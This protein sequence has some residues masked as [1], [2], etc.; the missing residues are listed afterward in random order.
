VDA[1][2]AEYATFL[3]MKIDTWNK[4]ILLMSISAFVAL[5]DQYYSIVEWDTVRRFLNQNRNG[6]NGKGIPTSK[7]FAQLLEITNSIGHN[8]V[9]IIKF[10]LTTTFEFQYIFPSMLVQFFL[11]SGY[12]LSKISKRKFKFK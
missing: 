2:E 3:G 11:D 4:V 9:Y 12:D 10:F 6:E 1:G 7:T 5:F 8:L